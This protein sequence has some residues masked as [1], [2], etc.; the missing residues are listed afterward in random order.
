MARGAVLSALVPLADLAALAEGFCQH[1]RNASTVLDRGL[2]DHTFCTIPNSTRTPLANLKRRPMQGRSGCGG[3][4]S[5]GDLGVL[6]AGGR[7]VLVL[8]AAHTSYPALNAAMTLFK[9]ICSGGR[10]YGAGPSCTSQIWQSDTFQAKGTRPIMLS[11]S[12]RFMAFSLIAAIAVLELS[13]IYAALAF[14][15]IY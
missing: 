13:M 9:T 15:I 8:E 3:D 11:R 1:T 4:E 5:G 10:W 7:S 12:L 6:H 14:L 2:S